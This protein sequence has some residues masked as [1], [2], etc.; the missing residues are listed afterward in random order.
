MRSNIHDIKKMYRRAA[1]TVRGF[2]RTMR[3]VAS[4]LMLGLN[5]RQWTAS[6]LIGLMLLPIFSLPVGATAA[7]NSTD[8]NI[9]DFE[10][11]NAPRWFWESANI[12]LNAELD[13]WL[14]PMRNRNSAFEGS[15]NGAEGETDKNGSGKK[16]VSENKAKSES[17]EKT[18]AES[19]N[20]ELPN[21]VD[22]P[23]ETSGKSLDPVTGNHPEDK[24]AL[25]VGENSNSSLK[26]NQS[27][28]TLM[29]S[30]TPTPA[31]II[32]P[33][34]IVSSSERIDQ[35]RDDDDDGCP[36]CGGGDD[37]PEPPP[38]SIWNRNLW[39]SLFT[40]DN[41]LGSPNGQMRMG[42][43]A[44]GVAGRSVER[45]GTGNFSFDIPAVSLPGR[46]IDAS[47]NIS[48]NSQ[49]WNKNGSEYLYN[50]AR[51]WMAPGFNLSFGTL[52][53]FGTGDGISY[54]LTSP[55][56]TRHQ[57]FY[58]GNAGGN[59]RIFE[60]ADGDFVQATYPIGPVLGGTANIWARFS[61]GSLVRYGNQD[62]SGRRYANEIVDRNGNHLSISY[63]PGNHNGRI[64][65]I[66]D[67]L[68][69]EI[70]FHYDNNANVAEKK[71]VT[72][73]VPG[74][75]TAPRRQA[76]RFYYEDIAFQPTGKFNGTAG[77][78]KSTTLPAT[79][80]VLRYVYFPGTKTG[81][82]YDYSTLFG[83][84]Y[85]ITALAG[86][87]VSDTTNLNATGS[88]TPNSGQWISWT[89][90]NYPTSGFGLGLTDVPKYT[91]RTDEWQ[92]R[93]TATPY[94][95]TYSVSDNTIDKE[96]T[97]SV[98]GPD[99]NTN[100]TKSHLKPPEEINN[101]FTQHWDDGLTKESLLVDASNN[102]LQKQ[103]FTWQQGAE[104][105]GRRNPQVGKI[106][107]TNEA[108]QSTETT[109][110]Y[111][112]FNNPTVVT[113][114]GFP[115]A[116][117]NRQE[118]RRTET[119]YVNGGDWMTVRLIRL[120]RE[121]RKIVNNEVVSKVK[122]EYDDSPNLPTQHN[123]HPPNI[124]RRTD[125][126]QHKYEYDPFANHDIY[127]I[128]SGQPP[129]L[130]EI[131]YPQKYYKGN[132]T[133]VTAYSNATLATDPNASETVMKYDMLGNSTEASLNCCNVK[134]WL[135]EKLTE[136]AYPKSITRGAGVQ[137]ITSAEYDLNTGLIKK[138][139]DPNAQETSYEYETNTLRPKKTIYPN[140]GFVLTEY[141]DQLITN[142]AQLVPGFV[143]T[144]TTLD[145][146]K[147]A[148]SYSYFD[149]RGATLRTATLTPD[150]W[151]V[152][153]VEYDSIGR[154]KKT[155]NPF[156]AATPN[157][158]VPSSVKFTEV[159]SYDSLSRTTQVRL[160]DTTIV[161]N[162]YNG[163]VA[164]VTDQAGKQR[165]QVAD[166]LGRIV[167][168]D[169][170]NAGGNLD[171]G[172]VP[173]QPTAYEYDG[174]DNL[175]K[176]TQTGNGATQ[177]RLFKYDSLSRLTHERQVEAIPTL[178][179]NGIRQETGG[180]WTK[181]L[182]YDSHGL[183]REAVDAR[184]VKTEFELYDG[185]NRVKK[186]K[187][188]DGTPT[189]NYYYD[190]TRTGFYNAGALTR[191]ETVVE[192]STP[193]GTLSTATE[194]DHDK[195]G[196]VI[197][198]RQTIDSQ[199]YNLEY[200]YNLAGQLTSEK[201]PSGKIV[202]TNYDA[203]G[204]LSNVADASRSYLN[205][206]QYQ[207]N[208]N[209][210]NLMTLGNG[211]S[212]NLVLNDRIQMSSQTLSKG[213]E[214]LQKYNYSYGQFDQNG[215][216]DTT[217]NNGQLAQIES[218]IGATK[219]FTQ[220]FSYDSLGRLSEAREQR[221]DTNALS[222]KQ[223]FD[224]DR[225]GNLY[226]KA[227]ANPTNGQD[228][229]Q[230]PLS[231]IPIE[232]GGISKQTNRFTSN[233]IYDDA[234]NVVKD[235]KFRNR[236]F[237][238]DANGRVIWTKLAD[239]TGLEAASIY[240]AS[241]HRVAT[242]TSDTWLFSIYD[243]NGKMIAEYG[244]LSATDEGGVRYLLKD[245]QGSTRAIVGQGGFVQARM[246]YTAL[247]EEINAGT[248]QRT[249]AQNFGVN[250]NFNH[251]YALTERDQGSDLDHTWFR[252][253]E[254]QAGR[255]TSPDPYNGSIS[256][257][258]PQSFNRYS[259]VENQ[260]T[261]FVD[262]SGLLWS[263]CKPFEA[264]WSYSGNTNGGRLKEWKIGERYVE[265]ELRYYYNLN[266]RFPSF[267]GYIAKEHGSETPE[268]STDCENFANA[269]S[270][271][272]ELYR[273]ELAASVLTGATLASWTYEYFSLI[274]QAVTGFRSELTASGQD[275]D[276]Y[277][278]ITFASADILLG[279][280]GQGVALDINRQALQ[281]AT[282]APLRQGEAKA[283]VAGNIAGLNVAGLILS[284]I[285]GNLT[286]DEL[287]NKIFGVL[288]VKIDKIE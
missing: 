51:N 135:Y 66:I 114:F 23:A 131:Y 8:E 252:K 267:N 2:A 189:V 168:V 17:S 81:F 33:G 133:K 287:K 112:N 288:C 165:R 166:A 84:I 106:K 255:W 206:L 94:T 272:T 96:R 14:I 73:T 176:V 27:I 186:V 19:V 117:G 136:Y 237:R 57:L 12:K 54:S 264:C 203:N 48:Y 39:D 238:Y 59:Y 180:L 28:A 253:L 157:G 220:K 219:Q 153:A 120:P 228:G 147:T 58:K 56:G 187:F 195:M 270:S 78:F 80:N 68:N 271:L 128:I 223:K 281:M 167:R 266:N 256:I 97:I 9:G 21:D 182:K 25:K 105:N 89:E 241:G 169:E 137:L 285:K 164:T 171:S 284:R 192:A 282:S 86:M 38:P 170:P 42:G 74:F 236:D 88:V 47:V 146:N 225:F 243:I 98:T 75:G 69:R 53:N 155:Y 11:V 99:G 183:L 134:T 111:D 55:N 173:A 234:G 72:I 231:Y 150:N 154:P 246:D 50:V 108:G 215:N 265:G 45:T 240:N 159:V 175:A 207:G 4:L 211:T 70:I 201:Y 127:V 101:V 178:D 10:P 22:P 247:G 151:S 212:Q 64:D 7:V 130:V 77:V 273:D 261:N 3:A 37:P 227:N 36:G 41:N 156:Y 210:L 1:A 259:Y 92:G 71:L 18:N 144:T 20:S 197:R 232:E 249:I 226:R 181:V 262:P 245:W 129:V 244:G 49:M 141:S 248:G 110:S 132:A 184:G 26:N 60:S 34:I 107:I 83:M 200:G 126:V 179:S 143:K 63:L 242:K 91:Q 95:H 5:A 125:A 142:A 196:Q 160:Q 13:K 235:T 268:L 260:P 222:Y 214:V 280:M 52:E 286:S 279:G 205:N 119:D 44:S 163:T 93:N 79:M 61:D 276:I 6:L 174:N 24:S 204:R 123:G 67:T 194:F 76:V 209:K 269:L 198:H 90:Y 104:V 118:L 113:E 65:R 149:G 216:L 121:I 250:I 40:A 239:G 275:S 233:I 29:P 263:D 277:R 87:E 213:T 278:H 230:S 283:S 102:V 32:M 185:L 115:D 162:S 193:V 217:Q 85:K 35:N 218:Y 82:R 158:Q 148:Q 109:Y 202:T 188:S 172:G 177:E 152:S 139:K 145:V 43:A 224:F 15:L 140:D 274:K 116:S 199:T 258:D 191:V 62:A 124:T 103:E 254:N 122:Y 208:G 190:E 30:P 31:A 16:V 161:Q 221:G 100:K 251:K 229:Q 257:T 46:G 138:S